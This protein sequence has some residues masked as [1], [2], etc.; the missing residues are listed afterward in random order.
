MIVNKDEY[1]GK[2]ILGQMNVDMGYKT[3]RCNHSDNIYGNKSI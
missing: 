2:W 1:L 3:V